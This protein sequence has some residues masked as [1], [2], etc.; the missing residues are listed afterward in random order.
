MTDFGDYPEEPF[1]DDMFRPTGYRT[2]PAL[3]ERLGKRGL[4]RYQGRPHCGPA[5]QRSLCRF[6]EGFVEQGVE[7]AAARGVRGGKAGLQPV[8]QRHQFIDL[9]DDAMLLGERREEDWNCSKFTLLKRRYGGTNLILREIEAA[10]NQVCP[11]KINVPRERN[12]EAVVVYCGG[13]FENS[14]FI[15]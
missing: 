12:S 5:S 10:K 15:C 6:V 14:P 3:C 1:Y 9:R 4:N 11:F 7:Q 2:D 8:A 13:S